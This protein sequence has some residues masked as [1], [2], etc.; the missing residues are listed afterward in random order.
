M[1]LWLRSPAGPSWTLPRRLAQAAIRYHI[2]LI[3]VMGP[4]LDFGSGGRGTTLALRFK[5][6]LI[7]HPQLRTKGNDSWHS[8][9]GLEGA[10]CVRRC[11]P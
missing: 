7:C 1:C 9:R 8:R 3:V 5:F 6:L 10:V 4:N 2:S 11:A